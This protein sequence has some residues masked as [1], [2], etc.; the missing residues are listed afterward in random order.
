MIKAGAIITAV[1]AAAVLV[2]ANPPAARAAN[3]D[4]TWT[5]TILTQAGNC[6]SSLRYAVRVVRGRVVGDDASY[7]VNGSV[8]ANGATMVTVSEKGQSASGSG[9][10]AGNSGSG[11]WRTRSGASLSGQ[12][13][14]R[15]R[16][17]SCGLRLL[18]CRQARAVPSAP[19]AIDRAVT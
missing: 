4:G 13:G 19:A 12:T 10:L 11:R 17:A 18:G 9:R 15:A 8:A 7:Q 3:F 5:V 2:T 1:A 16:V 6:P 14:R